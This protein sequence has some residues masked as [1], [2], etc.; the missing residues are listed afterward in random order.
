MATPVN[1]LLPPV[2]APKR[3]ASS[4][5]EATGPGDFRNKLERQATSATSET[6]R[7]EPKT[8]RPPRVRKP[9]Q[10]GRVR[11]DEHDAV[12]PR[13]AEPT[14]EAGAGAVPT[15]VEEAPE[16]AAVSVADE[17]EP[18]PAEEPKATADVTTTGTGSVVMDA[19]CQTPAP[20]DTP[21]SGDEA[22]ATAAPLRTAT[23]AQV[24]SVPTDLAQQTDEP[25]DGEAAASKNEA[26]PI[27]KSPFIG[28]EV[29]DTETD[30]TAE[31]PE[32]HARAVATT[33][34][35]DADAEPAAQIPQADD[36]P[37]GQL[38][39]VP[40]D[41]PDPSVTAAP[42][43]SEP[44]PAQHVPSSAP[45]A[46]PA[47]PEVRFAAANHETIVTSMRAEMLP[48]GGSMRIRLDPPQLGALQVT[49]QIQDGLVTAA[50]ETSTDEATR[51]LGHSLNQL[52]SVLESHGVAVDKLQVQQA[53]RET[54]TSARNDSQHPDQRGG[55]A[56]DQEQ[57]AHQEQQ[58]REMLRR[59]WRR[60]TGE[61]DPL[62][63]TA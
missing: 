60:L 19:T 45:P 30:D 36:A 28:G 40:I 20:S 23:P 41:L 31:Q 14:G 38:P 33:A 21:E 59:M 50:F 46:P 10:T 37:Q 49:V 35:V 61:P 26:K 17:A 22:G 32:A 5:A 24:I 25:S 7:N 16:D 9:Q 29:A 57:S 62:D 56:S 6:P 44:R 39:K 8:R 48:N 13:F 47:A 3:Q 55:H 58:R 54:Q 12:D 15:D 63:L 43:H 1:N 2:A 51:L 11:R 18:G 52:K 53:P 4:S 42:P 34:P 27:A